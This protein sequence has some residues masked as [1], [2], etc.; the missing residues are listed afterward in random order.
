MEDWEG[1]G[2]EGEEGKVQLFVWGVSGRERGRG[3]RARMGYEGAMG[4]ESGGEET[5]GNE[6]GLNGRDVQR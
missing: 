4:G 2:A 1:V 5:K 6:G 3:G